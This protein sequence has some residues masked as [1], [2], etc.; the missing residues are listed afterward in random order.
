MS[1][2]MSNAPSTTYL[3]QLL[4]PMTA[5][6]T[7]EYARKLVDLRAG[8]E[9]QDRIDELADKC[10][11]GTLTEAER[12]EYDTYVHGINMIA[13]LQAKARNLLRNEH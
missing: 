13:I 9:L 6:L 11:E 3:E 8:D 7:P 4:E 1:G 5:A 10:T 2:A 12:S